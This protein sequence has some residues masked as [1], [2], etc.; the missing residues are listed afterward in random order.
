MLTMPGPDYDALLKYERD[1]AAYHG[2]RIPRAEIIRHAVRELIK[3]G[4][5]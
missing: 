2:G 3:Q 1:L 5:E 4:F